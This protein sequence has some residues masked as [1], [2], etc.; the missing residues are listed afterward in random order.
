MSSTRS[1]LSSAA[2]ATVWLLALAAPGGTEATAQVCGPVGGGVPNPGPPVVVPSRSPPFYI[3][4][5]GY[6][7]SGIGGTGLP[8]SAVP[9]G[10]GGGYLA[11]RPL[12][13]GG[14]GFIAPPCP[15]YPTPY[16]GYGYGTTAY[17]SSGSGLTVNGVYSGD[18]WKVGFHLGTGP[19]GYVASNCGP[20]YLPPVCS[21]PL[22]GW[23]TAY[24]AY[25]GDYY[26]SSTYPV[27]PNTYG[28]DP[29]LWKNPQPPATTQPA[30]QPPATSSP[31]TP[32]ELGK[33]ALSQNEPKYAIEAF[34]RELK[35]TGNEPTT[36]RFLAIAL[37]EDKQFDDA[38]SVMRAAYR[39]GPA[40][41]SS[42][43]E[44]FGLGYS[45][46][47]FRELT[48]RCVHAANTKKTASSWLLV[49]ALMQAENR[50]E[51]A[52]RALEKASREGLEKDLSDALGAALRK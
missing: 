28:N 6:H 19:A 52:R 48:A 5:P 8:Q 25:W 41:A 37:A 3:P 38:A 11:P 23:T 51:P 40:L 43:I 22:W 14:N 26:P 21:Y 33:I 36:M 50:I 30:A 49:A 39:L 47:E 27:G 10:L 20:S 32:L 15:V 24:G 9:N 45:E 16:T 34:R 29:R 4:N 1:T 2:W 35:E 13:Q 7:F 17:V 18:K 42:P 12:S 44:L 46:R 31:P